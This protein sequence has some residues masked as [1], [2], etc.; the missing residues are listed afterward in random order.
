MDSP[1][2]RLPLEADH[3]PVVA[4]LSEGC[5]FG[6]LSA[7][8]VYHDRVTT[9]VA[10]RD[11]TVHV[12][13]GSNLLEV[14]GRHPPERA[15]LQARRVPKGVFGEGVFHRASQGR[16]N[17]AKIGGAKP[18]GGPSWKTPSP[19]TPFGTLQTAAPT[20]ASTPA[21]TAAGCE[22]GAVANMEGAEA[23]LMAP[24]PHLG[25]RVVPCSEGYI[26]AAIVECLEGALGIVDIFCDVIITFVFCCLGVDSYAE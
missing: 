21:P 6:E 18:L 1:P 4:A 25:Q 23:V 24:L 3:G 19:K 22:T 16:G 10:R 8:G 17:I 14:L 13:L 26:G 2:E 12:L 5:V 7:F 11:L 20:P 15:L 9:V